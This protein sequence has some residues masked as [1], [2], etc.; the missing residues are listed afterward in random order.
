[1]D[2]LS[3]VTTT[4]LIRVGLLGILSLIAYAIFGGIAIY[5]AECR[6][7]FITTFFTLLMSISSLLMKASWIILILGIIIKIIF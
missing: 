5:S 7:M 1:M 6:R 3:M 2:I 4:F